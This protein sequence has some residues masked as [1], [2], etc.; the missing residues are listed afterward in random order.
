[1]FKLAKRDQLG[2]RLL[3]LVIVLV[4]ANTA[5]TLWTYTNIKVYFPSGSTRLN[6]KQEAALDIADYHRRL[7]SEL[8]VLDRPVVREALAGFNYDVEMATSSEQLTQ[9][10]LNQGR[11]LQET[12]LREADA[13]SMDQVLAVVNQDENVRQTQDKL[14]LSLRISQDA[15]VTLPDSYL[16][17]STIYRIRQIFPAERL[18][19]EQVVNIEI[20][21]GKGRLMVPYNPVEHIQNLTEELDKLRLSLHE[22][23]SAAGLAEMIGPGI[24]VNLYDELGGTNYSSIIH[25]ADIRD[26]VNE[27]F[28]S[29]AM[30]VSVGGQR[31]IATSSIRC[32]GSLVKVNDKLIT[33]NPVVIK[34]VGDPKLLVSGLDIIK[35]TMEIRRGLRFEII[36]MDSV[37]LPAY[38]RSQQ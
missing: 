33:V 1:M 38:S 30:G 34:A 12:I 11:R 2:G 18:A 9:V 14:H 21:A 35:N 25:D 5:L 7:A 15:V 24:V 17:P 29:G 31:L 19:S 3:F 27:I 20:S 16:R 26:V 36:E 4:V 37:S 10:I 32:S 22:I 13:Y 28:G 23:R 8:G 6:Y